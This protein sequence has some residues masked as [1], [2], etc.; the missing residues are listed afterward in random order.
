[1]RLFSAAKALGAPVEPLV[2]TVTD[3]PGEKNSVRNRPSSAT[4]LRGAASRALDVHGPGVPSARTKS[5]ADQRRPLITMPASSAFLMD[6]SSRIDPPGWMT[7]VIPCFAASSTVSP[8]GKNASDA[9]T[10]PF[11]FSPASSKAIFAEPTR[12]IC[13]APTPSV[14]CS[15]VTTMALDFTCFT[16]LHANPNAR[17]C[18]SVGCTLVTTV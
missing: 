10:A 2:C 14:L 12:F 3:A 4:K 1:M 11:A 8:K 18:A 13:P 5:E 9:I 7:A 6:S 17:H 16:N 15:S